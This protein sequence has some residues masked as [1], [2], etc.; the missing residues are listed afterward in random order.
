MADW[1]IIIII[2]YNL[3][4]FFMILGFAWQNPQTLHLIKRLKY[5]NTYIKGI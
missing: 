3:I 1:H 4:L 5:V 2:H